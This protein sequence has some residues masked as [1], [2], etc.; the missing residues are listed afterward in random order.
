MTQHVMYANRAP[1][2]A[3]SFLPMCR[4]AQGGARGAGMCRDMPLRKTP[5]ATCTYSGGEEGLARDIVLRSIQ[6]TDRIER[7]HARTRRNSPHA[8]SHRHHPHILHLLLHTTQCSSSKTPTPTNPPR[9]TKYCK[10]VRN[11]PSSRSRTRARPGSRDV[12][13]RTFPGARTRRT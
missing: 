10:A 3:C 7:A 4:H 8:L 12:R 9:G 11:S 1:S 13:P 2:S 5:C 6:R